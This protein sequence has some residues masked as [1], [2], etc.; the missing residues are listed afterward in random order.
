[1]VRVQT[2]VSMQGR[3]A[4]SV[5]PALSARSRISHEVAGTIHILADS[6]A[7][8]AKLRHLAPRILMDM[9]E[10]WPNLTGIHVGT[11]PTPGADRKPDTRSL[12]ATGKEELTALS[13]RLP[14]GALKAAVLRISRR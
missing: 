6:A 3:Y 1:M 9:R 14:E 2:L 5:G 13:G 7:V 11:Q 8:A 4:Q 10:R 12:D